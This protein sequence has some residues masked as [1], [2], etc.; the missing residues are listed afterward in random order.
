MFQKI[1]SNIQSVRKNQDATFSR[2]IK[3]C[4]IWLWAFYPMINL[5][6]LNKARL[7][8]KGL[9]ISLVTAGFFLF[10]SSILPINKAIGQN[11]SLAFTNGYIGTQGSN[12]NQAN[13]IKKLSTLG[14]SRVSFSQSYSGTFGGT[15]GNDLSGTIKLYLSNAT[16]ITLTGALNWRE[17]TGSTVEVFGFIF[18]PGQTATISYGASQTLNILGGSTTASSSTMGLRAYASAFTFTDG[19]NRTGNAATSGLIAALNSELANTPQPSAITLANNSVKEAQ[20]LVYTLTLSSTT[21]V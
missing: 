18:D 6:L 7:Y 20:N 16:V 8:S 19:Q 10:I 5:A 1:R 9:K 14:I 13:G 21:N 2:A 3:N 17:T 12:T 4:R 15:Q 11:V